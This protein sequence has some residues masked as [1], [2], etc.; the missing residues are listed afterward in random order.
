MKIGF[1]GAGKV[2]FS[3]GRY[4][5][6]KSISINGY[7]SRNLISAEEAANFTKSLCFK[8]LGELVSICDIIFI[9]TPDDVIQEVWNNIKQLPIENKVICHCSGSLTSVIFE[10]IAEHKAYGYSL[11]PLYAI[12]SKMESYKSLE[13]AYFTL[14]GDKDRIEIVENLLNRLENPY[15]IISKKDK[16]LYH[17]AAVTVSNQVIALVN[18][19]VESLQKCGFVRNDAFKAL[20]PL[21]KGNLESIYNKGIEQALTGPIERN[22]IGTIKKHLNTLE[23]QDKLIY[24]LLSLKL[25]SIAE[26]K[27]PNQDYGLLKQ[28]L[29]KEMEI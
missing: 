10:G 18:Q 5:L 13:K 15:Q 14:E 8:D 22:D 28:I 9:T 7:Y 2:G 17:I 20:W 29:N 11:H 23:E 16:A 21:V 6:E 12:S 27:N 25:V 24:T 26:R 4:F 3:L 19:G 1:I